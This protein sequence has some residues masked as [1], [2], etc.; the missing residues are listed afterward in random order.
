MGRKNAVGTLHLRVFLPLC[1]LGDYNAV[2]YE[3]ITLRLHANRELTAIGD[4]GSSWRETTRKQ[5]LPSSA[6]SWYF[7]SWS[8]RSLSSSSS[9]TRRLASLYFLR[10][11]ARSRPQ[12]RSCCA[13]FS[14]LPAQ[15][16]SAGSQRSKIVAAAGRAWIPARKS[17]SI[18][19]RSPRPARVWRC[20]CSCT[21]C[22]QFGLFGGQLHDRQRRT[23]S[24]ENW[25]RAMSQ[26]PYP[27]DTASFCQRSS[28]S[29]SGQK[30][31]ASCLRKSRISG[32]Q[33]IAASSLGLVPAT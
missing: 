28:V 32:R 27:S 3:H 24:S 8:L 12:R 30:L 17:V 22:L 18:V 23:F 11:S 7:H 26:A 5:A 1:K 33:R 6:A 4:H 20:S 21:N 13:R 25:K 14:A 19:R 31:C 16:Q 10:C 9:R 2:P 29:G 15:A